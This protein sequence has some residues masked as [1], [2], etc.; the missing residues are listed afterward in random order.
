[1]VPSVLGVSGDEALRLVAA[2]EERMRSADP[3]AFKDAESWWPAI[4][5]QMRDGM[6]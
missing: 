6:L 5:E 2:T 3:T 1:V 4:I